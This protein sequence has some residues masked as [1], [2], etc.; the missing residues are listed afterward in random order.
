VFENE[1][2]GKM[3]GSK[4]VSS[5]SGMEKLGGKGKVVPVLD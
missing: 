4:R 1:E 2:S 5:A 3:F